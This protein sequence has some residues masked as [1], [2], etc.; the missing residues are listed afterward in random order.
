MPTIWTTTLATCALLCAA[1]IGH[2]AQATEPAPVMTRAQL[3]SVFEEDGGKHY[4][5][6]KLLPKAKL[7]FATLTFRLRDR[8]LLAGVTDGSWVKFSAQ[9]IDGENTVTAIQVVAECRRY[10]PCD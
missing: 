6:L 4:A 10:Q 1:S 7:P 3:V 8:A 5:R 2:T 9:R